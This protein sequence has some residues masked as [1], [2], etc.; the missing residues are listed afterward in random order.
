MYI[1]SSGP[2]FSSIC[3]ARSLNYTLLLFPFGTEIVLSP[4]VF[5]LLPPRTYAFTTRGLNIIPTPK[6]P[7]PTTSILQPVVDGQTPRVY[8]F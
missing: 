7:L 1:I 8:M 4:N 5:F 6:E 2:K 3:L